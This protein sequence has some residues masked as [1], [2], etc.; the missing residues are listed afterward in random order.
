M[1]NYTFVLDCSLTMAWLFEDESCH[2]STRILESLNH[3]VAVVPTIWPLEVGNVLLLAQRKKRITASKAC[4]FAEALTALPIVIDNTTS[5]RAMHS[6]LF[7]AQERGLT[8]YDAAYLELAIREEIP[9][10]TLDKELVIAAHA[11]GVLTTL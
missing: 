5:K 6:V 1:A 8:V 3:A 11:S 9:L 2:M 10:L 4:G 7:L